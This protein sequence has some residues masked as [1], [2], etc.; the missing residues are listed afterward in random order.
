MILHE[1]VVKK[2]DDLKPAP[3]NPRAISD[4]ALIGLGH[5]IKEFGLVQPIIWNKRTGH[6][7]GG[8]QRIKALQAAGETDAQVVVVDLEESREK[9]L[10]VALNSP[11]ISGQFTDHLQPILDAL[12]AEVPDLFDR[13]LLKELIGN[14][15]SQNINDPD[16]LPVA[17]VATTKPGDIWEM[18]DHLLVCGDAANRDDMEKCMGGGRVQAIFTDPPWNVA[19]GSDRNPRH[20][21]REGMINDNLGDVFPIFLSGWVNVCLPYL[22]GDFYCV[23]GCGEWPAIDKALRDAGMHWS[24]TIVWVK[25]QFVLGRSNYHRR[26]E[27]IWYGW[28]DDRS[29]SYVGDRKQ[30]DVWNVPRPKKSEEHPTM[31][32]VELV[33]NAILNSSERGDIVLD[34]FAGSGTTAIACERTG[35]HARLVEIDSHYCDV[36]VA[37][38]EKFTGRKATLKGLTLKE[39]NS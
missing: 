1:I 2:L 17:P 16:D 39:R 25:D 30:D 32:P 26:F 13:L 4:E 28:R 21:Q 5:S 11:A 37:R 24:A 22:D 35:R 8:H 3:Y 20:R 27:P 19:I 9:A 36:I 14:V 31:K 15:P 10:N 38:W 33:E 6:V 12:K 23:M 7:V 18:G 34:M 29:S